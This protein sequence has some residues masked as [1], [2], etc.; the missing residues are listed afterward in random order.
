MR[1][2]IITTSILGVDEF[3]DSITIVDK[4]E[5]WIKFINL[6][7][8]DPSINNINHIK[9]SYSCLLYTSCAA[10]TAVDAAEDEENIELSLI[11]ISL[12]FR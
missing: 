4:A 10:W 7:K 9:W 2:P 1:K 8:Y 3:K 11:H 12:S 6:D 5:D